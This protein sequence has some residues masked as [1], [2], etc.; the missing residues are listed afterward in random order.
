MK[1]L[2]S[3][4]SGRF[5]MAEWFQQRGI[6]LKAEEACPGW[7]LPRQNRQAGLSRGSSIARCD[8]PH[9]NDHDHDNCVL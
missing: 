9:V 6:D 3:L 5:H 2:L 7:E 1:D 4:F 8:F